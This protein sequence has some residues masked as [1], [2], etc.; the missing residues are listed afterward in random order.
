MAKTIRSTKEERKTYRV[1]TEAFHLIDL[2][3]VGLESDENNRVTKLKCVPRQIMGVCP[4]CNHVATKIHDYP[5]QRTIHDTPAAGH[6]VRLVFDVYRLECGQCQTIFTMSIRDVVPECTYTHRLVKWVAN[7]E[8]KQ[9]VQTLS[10]TTGLGY[11]LIESML[12]KTAEEKIID[13]VNNPIEVKRLGIDEISKHK[14]RGNY[15]LVLTDLEKRIVLDVLP[16]RNK[17]TLIKWL[18]NPPEGVD[19]S[20]L[21]TVAV[22]L[23]KHYRDAISEVFGDKVSIVADRLHVVQNLNRAIHKARKDA[24]AK[25]QTD[26]KKSN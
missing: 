7:P 26:E 4:K 14:G 9:D 19:L 6:H 11:K 16:D 2:D 18:K 22:D 3:I 20:P 13:R 21:N 24:Q 12:L 17:A 25:A 15:V 23:W 1:L 10:R 8:R 5:S